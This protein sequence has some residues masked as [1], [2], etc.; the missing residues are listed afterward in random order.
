MD[1]QKILL[2]GLQLKFVKLLQFCSISFVSTQISSL[3]RKVKVML[4]P[5]LIKYQ[6]M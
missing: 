4:S 5:R 3:D 6:A 1:V 2:W